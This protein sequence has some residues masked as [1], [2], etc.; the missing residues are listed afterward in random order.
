MAPLLPVLP[1]SPTSPTNTFYSPHRLQAVIPPG[2]WERHYGVLRNARVL[3]VDRHW[4]GKSPRVGPAAG[5]SG[6]IT[7]LVL[8]VARWPV[9]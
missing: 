7:P 2:V 9:R 8:R 3:V 5:G 4:G 1:G 6:G